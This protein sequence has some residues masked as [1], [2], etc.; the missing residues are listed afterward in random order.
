MAIQELLALLLKVL[1]SREVII[2]TA[3]IALYV[4]IV[5]WIVRYRKRPANAPRN[6]RRAAAAPPEEKAA[7]TAEDEED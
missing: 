7:E 5:L 3:V 1:T 4:N 2:V 6:R